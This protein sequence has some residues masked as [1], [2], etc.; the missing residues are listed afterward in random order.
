MIS[1]LKT[2][3]LLQWE[4]QAVLRLPARWELNLRKKGNIKVNEK[5][6]N[7]HPGTLCGR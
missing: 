3:Y 6:G 1:V 4:L 5:Y 2:V 7:N